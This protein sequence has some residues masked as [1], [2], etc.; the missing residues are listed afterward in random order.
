MTNE[1][2]VAAPFDPKHHSLPVVFYESVA[3]ADFHLLMLF[4]NGT[5][6]HHFETAAELPHCW[7]LVL[8]SNAVKKKNKQTNK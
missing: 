6:F 4:D 1:P 5:V 8:I 7:L 2:A 3:D